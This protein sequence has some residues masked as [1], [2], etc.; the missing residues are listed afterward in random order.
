MKWL[1]SFIGILAFATGFAQSDSTLTWTSADEAYANGQFS[2]ALQTWEHIQSS[3]D[4]KNPHLFYNMGNAAFKNNQL[5]KAIWYW[6][7]ALDL[8][9]NMED[10]QVNLAMAKQGIVDQIRPKE[11]SP[12]DQFTEDV[13]TAFTPN[14]WGI[15]SLLSFGLMA[16]SFIIFKKS[17]RSISGLLM[18]LAFIFMAFG[19]LG[20]LAG[21]KHQ[22]ELIKTDMAVVINPN[23]YV[24]TAP[25][26]GASDAFILHEGSEM[27]V[28]K[29]MGNWLEI[30]LADGKLGW[31]LDDQV[32][33][34]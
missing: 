31:V 34:Y 7:K 17:N 18:P 32:G 8:Q 3:T 19:I 27:K 14:M 9:P 26:I 16:I 20:T 25:M 6:N 30:K 13:Y 29:R 15:L 22:R 21:S 24:K 33:V 23:I 28:V 12:I 1:A 10:A 2:I 5:G 4:S 11:K